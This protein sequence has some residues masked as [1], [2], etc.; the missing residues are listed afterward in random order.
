MQRRMRIYITTFDDPVY[1]NPFLA[2]VIRALPTQVIGIGIVQ[3]SHLRARN[4]SQLGYLVT[5]ALI[6]EPFQMANMIAKKAGLAIADRIVK[7]RRRNPLSICKVA[8]EHQIPVDLVDDLNA[9]DFV[10]H[11]EALRPDIIVN[12]ADVILRKRFLSVPHIGCLNRHGALLPKYRG[13]LAPFWAY[14]EMEREIGVT[15]HLIERRLDSGPIVVQERIPIARFDTLASLL[16]KV[17]SAAPRA[18]VEA[19]RLL[20]REGYRDRLLPNDDRQASYYSDPMLGDAIRYRKVMVKR[21]L[22]G[23]R[24]PKGRAQNPR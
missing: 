2:Q 23:D 11:L 24:G 5:L 1:L 16:R 19:I 6:S 12:Q 4:Q 14:T 10:D 22:L 13:R 17:F 3:G 15:I 7:D 9:A 18:M 8:T 20:G 21:M